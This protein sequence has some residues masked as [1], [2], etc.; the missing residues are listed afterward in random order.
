MYALG[1]G[2]A[3]FLGATIDWK[4]Y[5]L[6]QLWISLI[7]LNTH[8]LN[9]YFDYRADQTNPNRTLF[10]GGSGALGAGKL[11]REVALWAGITCLTVAASITVLLMRVANLDARV[12]WI[13]GTIFLG[14]F[15][16]SNPP[17]RL[18]T[19][20]YGELTTSIIVANLVPAFAFLLQYEDFHRLLAMSTFP[21]TAFH[22]AMMIIF[23]F[24]DYAS[25]IKYEKNT[26]L[27]RIGWERGVTMHNVMILAGFLILG[28]ATLFG[29]PFPVALP[30]FLSLPLGLFQIWMI[31]RI[32]EGAKPNWKILTFTAAALLGVT[33]Y[34]MTFTFWTR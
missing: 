33:A 23:E 2:I 9:E 25:D 12:V 34:L 27:V 1:A 17:I 21:L 30:G 8:F 31:N 28:I 3:R 16:Y 10:S 20:G 24:P 11:P 29:L 19:S 4:V 7:Q 18:A 14:A 26:L 15:F 13:M 5:W 6:G 22:L 32:A